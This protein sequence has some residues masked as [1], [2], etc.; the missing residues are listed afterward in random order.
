[1]VNKDNHTCTHQRQR[2]EGIG[3]VL[4]TLAADVNM[5]QEMWGAGQ[6][7]I[8]RGIKT[9]NHQI[10]TGRS[11]W[12]STVLDTCWQY[13]C[14]K[15]GLWVSHGDSLVVQKTYK[16]QYTFSNTKSGKGMFAIFGY[17]NS[18]PVLLITTH[19]DPDN[20]NSAQ[21]RQLG[22]LSTFV[23]E[24]CTESCSA[25][26]KE[27]L[28]VVTAGDFNIPFSSKLYKTLLS[29]LGQCTDCGLLNKSATYDGP[30]AVWPSAKIDYIIVTE[31]LNNKTFASP[32][33][34]NYEHH[35]VSELSDHSPITVDII[36]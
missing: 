34:I 2:A 20:H 14:K 26:L 13:L 31:K 3:S 6:Q 4:S 7:E 22:E 19:L 18:R 21:E 1:M 16:Q 25:T 28:L 15:G 36:W 8:E 10:C 24:C 33:S 12:G 29:S 27:A 11:W 17:H 9:N 23:S 35:G 5:L 30:L 32:K